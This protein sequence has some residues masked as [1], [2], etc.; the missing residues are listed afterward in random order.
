MHSLPHIM[1]EN[2]WDRYGIKKLR[3]CHPTYTGP[4]KFRDFFKQHE[5]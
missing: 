1:V 5:F 3:H 4:L 2:S